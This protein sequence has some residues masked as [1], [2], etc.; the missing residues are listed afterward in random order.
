MDRRD[1]VCHWLN[2]HQAERLLL[3]VPVADASC[4]SGYT[5]CI[6]TQADVVEVITEGSLILNIVN[7]ACVQMPYSSFP[8]KLVVRVNPI[9]RYDNKADNLPFAR[10]GFG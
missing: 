2:M 6:A 1:D 5:F 4:S 9:S 7:T 8:R 3:S 10:R